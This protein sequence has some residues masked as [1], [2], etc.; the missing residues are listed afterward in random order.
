MHA[1]PCRPAG[2]TK[3]SLCLGRFFRSLPWVVSFLAAAAPAR[4][5][6]ITV[7]AAASLMDSLKQVAADYEKQSGDKIVFNFGASSF[8][9]RQI[10][11]GAPADIF[12][13]ADEAKMNDLEKQGLIL[14]GTRRSRLSNSLVIVVA[15]KDGAAVNAPKDL[16]TDRIQRIALAEPTTVPAGIY[17]KQFLQ[18]QGLW[19]AIQ[20]KVVPTENVRAALAAVESGN[21][22]A[23]I[24]YQTDAAI[25]KR[26]KI[27]YAVSA[28]DGPSIRYPVA[29]LKNASE[30]AAASKFLDYLG[31]SAAKEVFRRYG[32]IV[33]D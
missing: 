17:A 20:P 27:A 12:F 2:W 30:P 31:S 22:D 4:G 10:T 9:S 14:S 11:E 18:N 5:T 6:E 7:F 25:S 13:S 23:G 26:V 1:K 28:K 33:L 16:A 19:S 8:L 29:A 32:F 21:V 15:A 24:V 3:P